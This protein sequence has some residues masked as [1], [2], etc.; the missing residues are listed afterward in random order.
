MVLYVSSSFFCQQIVNYPRN[1]QNGCNGRM[2][3]YLFLSGRNDTFLGVN[4]AIKSNF[5]VS[6]LGISYFGNNVCVCVFYRY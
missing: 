3:F 2:R 5:A 6:Y 4:N 1:L